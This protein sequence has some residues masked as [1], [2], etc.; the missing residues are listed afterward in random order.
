M[1]LYLVSLDL[2][3]IA[4]ETL[5]RGSTG[6]R[7]I[8]AILALHERPGSSPSELADL[9]GVSRS[10]LS[11]SVRR[12]QSQG[13]V[14]RRRDDRDGRAAH[15]WLTPTAQERVAAFEDAIGDY[16]YRRRSTFSEVIDL[17]RGEGAVSHDAGRIT[18][19]LP[20]LAV[21]SRL[22]EAGAIAV[23]DIKAA[24]SDYALENLNDRAALVLIHDRGPVRPSDLA[25]S[26]YL[27]S[28]G[29]TLLVNRLVAH[30]LVHRQRPDDAP[31]RRVVLVACTPRG[32]EA[33]S[34]ICSVVQKH[35]SILVDALEAAA[36]VAWTDPT[37]AGG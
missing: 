9:T 32:S 2:S 17:I 11:R 1:L 37:D 33:A 13:L 20:P 23:D 21:V 16:L 18:E 14:A 7:D 26:L 15:L 36:A 19:P 6:N 10:S 22:A 25:A 35:G 27:T 3:A 30:G 24:L 34:A 12:L 8:Q 31:D 29:S 5:G 4:A 28:G